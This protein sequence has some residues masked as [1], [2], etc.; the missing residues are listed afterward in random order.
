M[1]ISLTKSKFKLECYG[2]IHF[3]FCEPFESLCSQI[4]SHSKF[5]FFLRLNEKGI[6]LQI[7]RKEA[8][9][10]THSL[11]FQTQGVHDCYLSS[12]EQSDEAFRPERDISGERDFH[13]E[14][15]YDHLFLENRSPFSWTQKKLKKKPNKPG[16]FL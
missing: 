12:S 9:C 5:N 13:N 14:M 6:K 7:F 3:L 4:K 15:R 2:G 1:Y 11:V 8:T 10:N 16:M